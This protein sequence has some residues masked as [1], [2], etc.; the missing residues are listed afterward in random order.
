MKNLSTAGTC[1]VCFATRDTAAEKMYLEAEVLRLCTQWTDTTCLPCKRGMF[2][3][4]CEG[5]WIC[6]ENAFC[7]GLVTVPV[8]T[9]YST[10]VLESLNRRLLEISTPVSE[11]RETPA[12]VGAPFVEERT[13]RTCPAQAPQTCPFPA[14]RVSVTAS[15][16]PSTSSTSLH[17][18]RMEMPAVYRKRIEQAGKAVETDTGVRVAVLGVNRA[19]DLFSIHVSGVRT[20][21]DAA[22]DRLNQVRCVVGSEFLVCTGLHVWYG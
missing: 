4:V 2:L 15:A 19:S 10:I 3:L 8:T 1:L 14:E 21:V 13:E 7:R 18:I 20:A 11:V 22:Q 5:F 16:V 12:D 9:E 17:S 6:G